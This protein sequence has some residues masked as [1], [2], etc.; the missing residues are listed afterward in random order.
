M[1]KPDDLFRAMLLELMELRYGS[2]S[3]IFC[4]QYRSKDWHA[5]L[6]GEANAEA[7]M[8]RIAS[9]PS[10]WRWVRQDARHIRLTVLNGHRRY[11]FTIPPVLSRNIRGTETRKYS[12]YLFS[13]ALNI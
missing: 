4:T 3:T 12:K 11:R 7:I 13:L 9:A 8:D 6:G 1:D 2:S 10:G 5:G